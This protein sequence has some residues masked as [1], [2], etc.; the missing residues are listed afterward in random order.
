MQNY[1][2]HISDDKKK[3]LSRE[4]SIIGSAGVVGLVLAPS[5]ADASTAEL[6]TMLTDIGTLGAAAATVVIAVMSVRLG[7]KLVNRVAVK[8]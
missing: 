1:T 7:I 6:T 8:G 4:A 2:F 5:Q 3:M